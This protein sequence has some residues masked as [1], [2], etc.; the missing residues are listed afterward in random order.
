MS[1]NCHELID[2]LEKTHSLDE[3]EYLQLLSNDLPSDEAEYLR[4]RA[5]LV[6][7]QYF[8]RNVRIRGL[9]E[10]TNV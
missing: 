3:A 9:I 4:Q 1:L 2:K 10:I 7:D 6:T 5:R 8:G